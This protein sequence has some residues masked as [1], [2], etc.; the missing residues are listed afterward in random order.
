MLQSLTTIAA[1]NR[2]S[3]TTSPKDLRPLA[4]VQ[5]YRFDAAVQRLVVDH[6]ITRRDAELLFANTLKMLWLMAHH[7]AERYS[8]GAVSPNFP[9]TIFVYEPMLPL[10]EGWHT[11]ILFTKEYSDFCKNFLGG[12]LHHAPTTAEDSARDQTLF[13]VDPD[14]FLNKREQEIRNQCSYIVKGLGPETLRLWF[15]DFPERFAS[16]FDKSE[17]ESA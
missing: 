16:M 3:G 15:D 2:H 9:S 1:P 7:R 17:C 6:S 5:A 14:G 11:F 10:D 4:E 8:S 12:Y 13:D